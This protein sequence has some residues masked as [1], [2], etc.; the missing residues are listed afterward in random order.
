MTLV[1]RLRY[2]LYLAAVVGAVLILA[3]SIA[4][5][6]GWLPPSADKV[7]LNPFFPF[8]LYLVAYLVAPSV[9]RRFPIV[10]NRS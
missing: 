10:R 2:S 4:D 7:L 9:S 8:A 1:E 3:V 6:V 5:A